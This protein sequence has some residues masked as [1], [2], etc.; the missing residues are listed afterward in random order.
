VKI[1]PMLDMCAKS[2]G[3][4]DSKRTCTNTMT[5][6]TC[7]NC[8]AGYV[9]SGATGCRA[10]GGKCANGNL[11]AQ[12]SR[13]Q[14]NHCGSCVTRA[15][16]SGRNC[17]CKTGY[18]GTN[19][20]SRSNRC[21]TGGDGWV[22]FGSWRFGCKDANHWVISHSNDNRHSMR[23]FRNDGTIYGTVG[24]WSLWDKKLGSLDNNANNILFGDG[25]M[26][27]GLFRFGQTEGGKGPGSRGS[28]SAHFTISTSKMNIY[29][30][31]GDGYRVKQNSHG[32]WHKSSTNQ[33]NGI[34]KNFLELG[35]WR[36]GQV[37]SEH[38]S[39]GYRTGTVMIWRNDKT[40]HGRSASTDWSTWSNGNSYGSP[41][42]CGL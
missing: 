25:F 33:N 41:I 26:Q 14:D 32:T 28:T 5:S 24:G 15:K 13:R 34:G 40:W 39:I 4:C 17:I 37:D 11:I 10:Y 23:I 19:C 2:N 35:G 8:P 9:N 20:A 31:R 30:W 7:G 6:R 36:F 12:G 16:M 3:G 27:C 21:V 1:A 38:S 22:Q 29:I 42:V 18:S